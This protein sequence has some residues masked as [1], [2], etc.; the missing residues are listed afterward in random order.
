MGRRRFVQIGLELV[1]VGNDY[2]PDTGRSVVVVGDRHYDG[3]RA[4]DGTDISTRAKHREYMRRNGL[5]TIDDYKN[6][7]SEA[8]RRRAAHYTDG[9]GDRPARLEDVARAVHEINRRK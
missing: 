2:V 3:L 8:A 1:E 5:T 4:S 6:E 7:W 9:S